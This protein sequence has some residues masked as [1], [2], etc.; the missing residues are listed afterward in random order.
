[1]LPDTSSAQ[2]TRVLLPVELFV[3]D[4]A[5]DLFIVVFIATGQE[6]VNVYSSLSSAPSVAA[7]AASRR[8]AWR[9]SCGLCQW[10]L[11]SLYLFPRVRVPVVEVLVLNVI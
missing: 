1:V 10:R 9:T 6:S 5:V 2:H 3:F 11:R 8:S 7:I 4:T